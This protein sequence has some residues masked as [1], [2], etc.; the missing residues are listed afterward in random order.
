MPVQPLHGL[1]E[2]HG[3]PI[4]R[5]PKNIPRTAAVGNIGQRAPVVVPDAYIA[6]AC[7]AAAELGFG[8]YQM[9]ANC[10]EHS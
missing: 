2:I 9:T 7:G 3:E 10:S 4:S 6:F 1:I 8:G 5:R